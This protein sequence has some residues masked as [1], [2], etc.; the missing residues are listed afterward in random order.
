MRVTRIFAIISLTVAL[1]A[2]GG[3]GKSSRDGTTGGADTGGV[4]DSSA[5]D[6][7][8]ANNSPL[9]AECTTAPFTVHVVRDGGIAA[10]SDTYQVIGAAAVQIPLVPDKTQTLPPDQA[11]ELSQSTDLIGYGLLFG[12]EPFGVNDVSLFDGYAPEA[13]GK[14]RGV[15]SVYPS[16]LT[17]LAVGD[18]V[19]P[20]PMDALQM[21]T[22][23]NNL[24]MDFKTAPDEY[25]SYVGSIRG[26]VTILGLN[27]EAI[28]LDVD[29]AWDASAISS[30]ATGT[31]TIQGIFTAPLAE[32][33][34][35]LG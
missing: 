14:S 6:T 28:C 4:N 24:G 33:T 25:M 31:L 2:C 7:S 1:A 17:P 26:S 5:G 11:I 8:P 21:Y 23:L 35:P 18:V 32:R 15:V 34:L 29:L 9:P 16:T 30:S 27:D 19:T 22:T 13:A 12:D 20:Q 10:G 3:S